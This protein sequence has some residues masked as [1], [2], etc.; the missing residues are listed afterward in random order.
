MT[1]VSQPG[2][3]TAMEL[4]NWNNRSWVTA[5]MINPALVAASLVAAANTFESESE[6]GM[7][8]ELAFLVAPMALHRD[9]RE[10][11]PTRVDSHASKWVTEHAALLA[12]LPGRIVSMRPYTREGL[13]YGLRSGSLSL[14]GEGLLL[15]RP[16]WKLN[17]TRDPELTYIVGRAAFLGRW[18]AHV[19]SPATLFALLGVQ[20]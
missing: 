19:G 18:F 7:P 10:A 2:I 15:G 14:T 8:W 13:R 20:P 16:E 3:R 6:D 11:L 17:K 12:T 9:T 5:S 4:P 1:D